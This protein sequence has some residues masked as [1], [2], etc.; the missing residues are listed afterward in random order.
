[1]GKVEPMKNF[2]FSIVESRLS[3][4]NLL[5][6]ISVDH[7][8]FLIIRMLQNIRFPMPTRLLYRSKLWV[9]N[10]VTYRNAEKPLRQSRSC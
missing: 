7:T 9:E 4:C 6:K 10:H 1:M 2:T 3:Y 5:H 8:T